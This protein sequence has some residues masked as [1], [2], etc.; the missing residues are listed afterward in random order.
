[1]SLHRSFVEIF[2]WTILWLVVSF[3][4]GVFFGDHVWLLIPIT[5][6]GYGFVA[7]IIYSVLSFI[8]RWKKG[9][10]NLAYAMLLGLLA[11]M[12]TAPILI[13]WGVRTEAAFIFTAIAG[14]L[15]GGVVNLLIQRK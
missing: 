1:M 7:G 9:N 2:S 6:T 8:F 10:F 14:T 5:G 11:S 13:A 4:Y 15:T 3:L 12:L